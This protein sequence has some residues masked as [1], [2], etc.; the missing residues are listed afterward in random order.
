ML[1]ILSQATVHNKQLQWSP[2]GCPFLDTAALHTYVYTYKNTLLRF[3]KAVRVLFMV[4][5]SLS[6]RWIQLMKIYV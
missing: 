6:A 4:A 5:C 3:N 1:K 2:E